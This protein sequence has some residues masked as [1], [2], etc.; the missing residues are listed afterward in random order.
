MRTCSEG[1]DIQDITPCSVGAA[2]PFMCHPLCL[3]ALP[4]RSD[5][6]PTVLHFRIAYDVTICGNQ[7]A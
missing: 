1:K 6:S 4:I 5:D 3:V 7:C 2:S